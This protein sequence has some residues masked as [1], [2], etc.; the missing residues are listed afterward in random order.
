TRAGA[1]RRSRSDGAPRGGDV[2]GDRGHEIRDA[3]EGTLVPQP[4][5]ELERDPATVEI[6]LEVEQVSLDAKNVASEVRVD[7]DRDRCATAERCA[8]VDPLRG[9]R[10]ALIEGEGGRGEAEVPPAPVPLDVHARE[11][12]RT[13]VQPCRTRE[14]RGGHEPGEV[15]A[16]R[17]HARAMRR[18]ASAGAR[19]R[20][21]GSRRSNASSE[22]ISRS[23]SASSTLNGP[24]SS[25]RNV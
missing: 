1:V 24:T 20:A 25:R 8:C 16:L 6:A 12:G 21:A 23:G 3:R 18:R 10:L 19:P 11:R 9:Q 17:A 13:P 15:V 14:I 5:P 4:L 22:S 2:V 7:A